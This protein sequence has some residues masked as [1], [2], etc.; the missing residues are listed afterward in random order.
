MSDT[1]N[2][3]GLNL[4]VFMP[5]DNDFCSYAEEKEE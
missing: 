4:S 3:M 2:L 5:Y 1:K